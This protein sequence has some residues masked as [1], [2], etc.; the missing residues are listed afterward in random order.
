M[1]AK[2]KFLRDNLAENRNIQGVWNK[3]IYGE[4][5]S[6][7]AEMLPKDSSV[8]FSR[9]VYLLRFVSVCFACIL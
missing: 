8:F 7:R 3:Q 6:D 1:L 5:D 2:N 4:V 9:E